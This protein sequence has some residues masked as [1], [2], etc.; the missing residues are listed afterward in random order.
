MAPNDQDGAMGV[1]DDVVGHAA[2]EEP[3]HLAAAVTANDD[4]VHLLAAG[5]FDD[6][7]AGVAVPDEE[8]HLHAV[9][10]RANR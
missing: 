5:R 8:I 6:R 2:D 9:L 3:A 4:E 7:L 1:P 10:A